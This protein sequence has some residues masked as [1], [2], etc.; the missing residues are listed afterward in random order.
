MSEQYEKYLKSLPKKERKKIQAI[1]DQILKWELNTIDYIEL[2]GKK[3]FF[4]TKYKQFRITFYKDN[5]SFK[6]WRIWPR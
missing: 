4:R 6:I 3:W 1:I 5:W 2:Q